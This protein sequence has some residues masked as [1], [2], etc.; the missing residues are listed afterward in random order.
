VVKTYRHRVVNLNRQGVVNLV[1]I[2]TLFIIATE[3]HLG[4]KQKELK[5]REISI[6]EKVGNYEYEIPEF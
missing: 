3:L 4:K 1:R 5:H 6:I 2:S